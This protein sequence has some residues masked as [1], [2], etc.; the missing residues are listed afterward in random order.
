MQN[1]L[2]CRTQLQSDTEQA[3]RIRSTGGQSLKGTTDENG[4]TEWVVRDVREVLAFD[5]LQDD[6]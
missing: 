4:Y 6:A 1:R 3:V 5:L 2:R